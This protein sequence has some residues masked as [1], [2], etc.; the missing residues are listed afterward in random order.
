[1]EKRSLLTLVGGTKRHLA[2]RTQ[3]TTSKRQIVTKAP[4]KSIHNALKVLPKNGFEKKSDSPFFLGLQE[5]K[6]KVAITDVDGDF[7]YEELFKRSFYLSLEIKK[8]L[9]NQPN[10]N[11]KINLICPNGANY[12]IGQWGIWMSGNVV[13]P[14]SGQHSETALEYYITD[15]DSSLIISSPALLH[16]VENVAKKVGKP[17]ICQD[18]DIVA[19][20]NIDIDG[21]APFPSPIFQ[22]TLY[23]KDEP[24]MMLYL[25]GSHD[26]SQPQRL[27]LKHKDINRE[28]DMVSK[29][30]NLDQ[31][32]SLL[33]S[34]SLYNPFGII[35]S[36]LT[37]LSVGGRVVL[38]PQFDTLKVWSHLLGIQINGEYVPRTNIYAGVPTH[39]EHLM[40]RYTEVFTDPKIKNYVH[41]TCSKRI[42][43]MVSGN[44]P[45]NN[46]LQKQWTKITGHTIQL[47]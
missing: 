37:P 34:L 36:L 2:R 29:V 47:Y 20:K 43:L 11:Q 35:S 23:P 22:D 21:K 18:P 45:L 6:N 19:H 17:L 39:Y 33:H 12:V 46:D 25:P 1:M 5:H 3:S 40:R 16:K 42:N 7:T 10:K 9:K 8:A 28:I 15:S 27:L 4:S 38:L 14:L 32:A 24:V 44:D 31:N 13:V 30:W 41:E 26:K